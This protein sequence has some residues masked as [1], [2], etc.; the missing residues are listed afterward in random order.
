MQSEETPHSKG[1]E[2]S[3]VRTY[4]VSVEDL[5]DLGDGRTWSQVTEWN[6]KW[7]CL[8]VKFSDGTEK[9][10]E[11]DGDFTEGINTKIPTRVEFRSVKQDGTVDWSGEPL[12]QSD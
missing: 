9:F 3:V 12:D 11:M 10:F 7:G 8:W 5:V 4:S 2:V 1:R 6:V